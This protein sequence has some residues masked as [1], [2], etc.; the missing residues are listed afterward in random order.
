MF[1]SFLTTILRNLRKNKAHSFINIAGLS[2]GMAVA[3]LICLWIW[4]E[5][6]FDKYHK[7]YDRIAQVM[8]NE[9]FSG[10]VSTTKGNVIPLAAEL[11][12]SY[13]GDFKYVVLSSW[14]MNSLLAFGEKRINTQGSYMEVDAPEM[15]TLKMIAGSRKGLALSSSVILSESTAKALFGSDDPMGKVIKINVDA[16]AKVTGVYEDLPQNTSFKDVSFIAPF[17]DLT[18]WVRG[19]E[20]NWTNESFQL[21][22]QMADKTD[23]AK[24]SAKMKDIKLGKIDATTARREKPEMLLHPMSKWHL[25]SEFKNG[26]SVGGAIQYVWMFSWIGVFV[27]LLACINFMNLSTA[28]SEKRAKEV[29][30]RKA[31][32][33]LRSQ[34]IWQFFCES[35]VVAFVAFLFSVL[36]VLLIVPFFNQVSGKQIA[37]PWGNI[38]FWLAAIG[39]SLVTG[40]IAGTYPALYLSSFQPVRVLKGTFKGGRSAV[41]PRK[42]LVVAQFTVSIILII[43]TITVFRQVQFA[44]SRPL[45]YSK[46]GL[47]T[48]VMQT[49]N[50]HKNLANMRNELLQQGAIVD[51]EESNTPVTENDHFDNGFAWAGKDPQTSA[52]FNTVCVGFEYGQTVGWE[53]VDGRDFSKQSVTDSSGIVL[54]EAAVKYLGFKKPVGENIKWYDKNLKVL[55]VIK[56]M[57]MESPYEAAKPTIFYVDSAI[58]GIVNIRLSSNMTTA[59]SLAKVAA[60]C[61]EYSPEESFNYHFADEEYARKFMDEERVGKLVGYFAVL[62]IFISCL[63]L[64]GMASFV[65]EQRTREIGVRKVFGASVFNLWG[66]L[67]KDFVVLVIISMLIA[68]PLAYHFMT[69]WLQHYALRTDLSWWVFVATGAGALLITLLT[70]SY[71]SIKAALANPVKSLRPE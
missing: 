55:G 51:M 3:M 61:K 19:N 9:T 39:F 18:G 35:M 7:N 54:N 33:S 45:G 57:A 15:L 49:D 58:G 37:I 44:K 29:G 28:R 71:Q 22:V 59:A 38:Y 27:L 30:I 70:V 32:G 24:L 21:F 14:N 68:T 42:I 41:I 36:M 5:L 40:I 60:V 67:N 56:D 65:A 25:Y 63:G 10:T 4:D 66:L 11:R 62:A 8:Q 26:V 52:K 34:L 50:Y 69:S 1:R 6:Q 53:F 43:S 12:R 2:V 48:L 13:G 20:N 31:I 64:F 17:F 16:N 46:Q 47:I 23:M